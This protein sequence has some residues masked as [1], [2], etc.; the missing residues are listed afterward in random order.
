MI[1]DFINNLIVLPFLKYP[2]VYEK[3]TSYIYLNLYPNFIFEIQILVN[4]CLLVNCL[5]FVFVDLS[6]VL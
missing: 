5:V 6:V 2:L 4:M 3:K 1:L